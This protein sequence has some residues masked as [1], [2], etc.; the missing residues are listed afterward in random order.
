MTVT[1]FGNQAVDLSAER[2]TLTYGNITT[3]FEDPSYDY[4]KAQKGAFGS[5]I[6]FFINTFYA[7]GYNTPV[8]AWKVPAD[9]LKFPAIRALFFGRI[10][11]EGEEQATKC[12]KVLCEALAHVDKLDFYN[13]G[14]SYI[15]GEPTIEELRK[16]P[17][18]N[19]GHKVE[20]WLASLDGWKKSTNK[21]D[22]I[23]K[24]DVID[25]HGKYWQ[26]KA[27]LATDT[28]K[29]SFAT[30]NTVKF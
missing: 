21:Q 27:T 6:I 26:I 18:D 23:L 15:G 28:T 4:I 5:G 2:F 7:R 11:A 14:I 30:Y 8:T 25:P 13:L 24:I 9:T 1:F 22:S 12:S 20:N 3:A 16:M 29:G 17:G 10:K 19:L